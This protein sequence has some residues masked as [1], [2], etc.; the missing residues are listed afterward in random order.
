MNKKYIISGLLSIVMLITT[1]CGTIISSE[2]AKDDNN[3]S[4]RELYK[5]AK[6]DVGTYMCI[7]ENDNGMTKGDKIATLLWLT[8]LTIVDLPLSAVVD[9]LLI[10]VDLT[11]K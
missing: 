1:G 7:L 3:I 2:L 5:G 4:R 9:T 10:P 11:R 8:P 6:F